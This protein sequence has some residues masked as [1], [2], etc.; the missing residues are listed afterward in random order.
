MHPE[1]ATE[2]SQVA[3][4]ELGPCSETVPTS[5]KPTDVFGSDPHRMER[6]EGLPGVGALGPG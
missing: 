4:P 6:Q 2:K 3:K 5:G 1:E